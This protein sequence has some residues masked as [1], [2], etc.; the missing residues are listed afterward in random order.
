[1]VGF[2]TIE[3]DLVSYSKPSGC[4]CTVL[5]VKRPEDIAVGLAVIPVVSIVLWIAI[6]NMLNVDHGGF[7]DS[8]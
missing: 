6:R 2:P 4:M 8:G 5:E 7:A 1:L 3:G